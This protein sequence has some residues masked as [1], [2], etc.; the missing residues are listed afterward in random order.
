MLSAGIGGWLP[1]A[2]W[3]YFALV[4][5][6]VQAVALAGV[7]MIVPTAVRTRVVWRPGL[8]PVLVYFGAIGFAYLAAEIAAIQQLSLLL[9]HPV[10]AVAGVLAVLLVCSGVGSAWSDRVGAGRGALGA[11]TLGALLVACGLGLLGLVHGLQG[12]PWL[13]R[14]F[15]AAAV[16]APIAFLMGMPFPMGL[17][18]LAG[19]DQTRIAWAWAVN[20]FASVV[21]APLA[22]LIALETG[23][24]V[25]FGA[26]AVA[27]GVAALVQYGT[28]RHAGG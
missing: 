10:Y 12:A 11:G 3:G 25:L 27:Y 23:T 22:A 21:A 13:V 20:G 24:R 26:A 5:T 2:E 28:T 19:R 16:L 1:F 17:R 15:A 6:L 8:M 4:A 7:L 18:A 14:G 9:G